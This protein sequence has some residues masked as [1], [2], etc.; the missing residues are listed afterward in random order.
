MAMRQPAADSA[1]AAQKEAERTG[2]PAF[3]TEMQWRSVEALMTERLAVAGSYLFWEGEQA[4]KLYIVLSGKVK[5][6]KS[7]EDGKA[8]ILS[9]LQKGDLMGGPEAGRQSAYGCSAEVAQ[10]ARIGVIVWKDL[11]ELLLSSGE[12]AVRWMNGMALQ[13]R[14][15]ESKFRDLLLYGKPGALASTLIRLS[16]SYGRLRP[17]G[18]EIGL[19]LTNAEL[20]EF[21]G[22]TRE[23]VNRMLA[24]MKHEG[25]LSVQGGLI[26]I[27]DL[28]A[29]RRVCGCPGC[30]ACPKEVCRI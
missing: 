29:L 27:V 1:Y 3:F 10:D 6:R 17:G 24:S 9:I 12:L 14:I 21:I 30:P 16:N 5:L 20:A 15:A 26:T 25:I 22:T 28:P 8:F 13:Q 7:T 18:L 23:S 2:Y 19:R 11:E 4:D